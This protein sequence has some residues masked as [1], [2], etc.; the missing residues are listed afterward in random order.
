MENPYSSPQKCDNPAA[1]SRWQRERLAAIGE[2]GVTWE[3][4]RVWYNVM[5]ACV[6][7]IAVLVIEPRLLLHARSLESLVAG[8]I[9]AN[10]CYFAGPI[11]EGYLT[12]WWRPVRWFR[13]PAFI[14]GTLFACLLT[15]V[16][17]GMAYDQM[18]GTID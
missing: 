5:L 8:A 11:I 1:K 17:V 4:L 9:G 10:L 7:S 2:V 6:A 13:I 15:W 14:A 16:V 3:Q 12:W 18:A